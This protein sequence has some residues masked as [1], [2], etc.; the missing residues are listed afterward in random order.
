MMCRMVCASRS[1]RCTGSSLDLNVPG[2]KSTPAPAEALHAGYARAGAYTD[3]FSTELPGHVTRA[4]FVEAFYTTWIFKLERW[5]LAWAVARPSTD[6]DARELAAGVRDRFA[7]WTVE[8]RATDQL[9]MCDYLKHT[10]S[11]LMV[12][13]CVLDGQPATRLYFG[14]VVVPVTRLPYKLLLGFHRLYSRVLLSSA[15]TRLAKLRA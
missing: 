12:A 9:L 1:G 5:I 8:S 6:D 11:W 4:Q 13:A 7:A 14:S 2:I 15:R 10:R 3:C